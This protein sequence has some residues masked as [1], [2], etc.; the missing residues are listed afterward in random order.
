MDF[1]T[2]SWATQPT[3]LPVSHPSSSDATVSADD[4]AK[5]AP[6]SSNQPLT[7]HPPSTLDFPDTFPFDGSEQLPQRPDSSLYSL[8]TTTPSPTTVTPFW[9]NAGPYPFN[10]APTHYT[11]QYPYPISSYSTLN[12][13]TGSSPVPPPQQ[14]QPQQQTQFAIDPALVSN[15]SP[16]ST[17][18]HQYQQSPLSQYSPGFIPTQSQPHVQQR[19]MSLNPQLLHSNLPQSAAPSDLSNLTPP[20]PP[21]PPRPDIK[22][23]LESLLGSGGLTG[24]TPALV[25]LIKDVKAYGHNDIDPELLTEFLS[26]VSMRADDQFLKAWADSEEAMEILKDWLKAGAIKKDEGRWVQTINPILAVLGRMRLSLDTLKSTKLGKIIVKLT[27]DSNPATRD[28]S[29]QLEKKWRDLVTGDAPAKK[30]PGEEPPSKKRKADSSSAKNAPPTKKLALSSS[31]GVKPPLTKREPKVVVTAVK[32]VKSDSSFFTEKKAKPKLPSFKKTA[33]GSSGSAPSKETEN[34]A[35]PSSIDPFQEALKSM[36]KRISSPKVE[37]P[38]PPA[39]APPLTNTSNLGKNGKP[40]KRVSFRPDDKIEQIRYIE[41]AIYDDDSDTLHGMHNLRDLEQAEGAALHAHLFEEQIDWTE[42][43]LLEL[44]PD[45]LIPRGEDSIEKT[46]QEEREKSALGALYMSSAQIPDSPFEPSVLPPE[47]PDA[48]AKPMLTGAEV[49]SLTGVSPSVADLLG[50]ISA[51]LPAPMNDAPMS[52]ALPMEEQLPSV[53]LDTNLLAALQNI[54][55]E[56][57]KQLLVAQMP[58]P[59]AGFQN[60]NFPGTGDPNWNYAQYGQVGTANPTGFDGDE[61]SRRQ[62]DSVEQNWGGRGRG[63]G[64][65]FRGRGGRGGG[66]G[67]RS[68]QPKPCTF[69]Q[70]GRCKYGDSC[71]FLH[72]A[73]SGY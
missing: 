46:T 11:N 38:T 28:L 42:P 12:G 64:D 20:M 25:Q 14:S 34:V 48:E 24:G 71:D 23:S 21:T 19:T 61:R 9:Y 18:I 45:T 47:N 58:M 17:P 69:Y 63:R 33:P 1:F 35:Q 22:A 59:D 26:K 39:S 50:Q 16:T 57:L 3:H 65:G 53:S 44:P 15:I 41:K 36:G 52:Q 60:H 32:D 37:V 43:L 67:F 55:P 68:K 30:E 70:Q 51:S 29:V 66:G 27:K 4:W 8:P 6:S 56:Q 7:S 31:A 73:P 54:G 5:A 72:E 40:K 49:D 62:W 2:S 10:P 13:A